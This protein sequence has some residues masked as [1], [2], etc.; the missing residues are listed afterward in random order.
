MPIA[1]VLFLF[2]LLPASAGAQTIY[3]CLA[4]D[5]VPHYQSQA[6]AQG[7]RLIQVWESG[8][9]MPA[10]SPVRAPR[11]PDPGYLSRL[12][13]TDRPRGGGAHLIALGGSSACV[14]ARAKRERALEAAGMDRDYDLVRRLNDAVYDACK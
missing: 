13:G 2:L 10:F 11:R 9:V 5:G 4:A 8:T 3:K 6:C 14:S 1:V 7:M 12:A